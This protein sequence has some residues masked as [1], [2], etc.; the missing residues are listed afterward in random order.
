MLRS[1]LLAA[2]LMLV[3]VSSLAATTAF[4]FSASVTDVQGQGTINVELLSAFTGLTTPGTVITGAFSYDPTDA[5]VP[6]GSDNTRTQLGAG[7]SVVAPSFNTFMAGMT[8]VGKTS[9]IS[10]YSAT[11]DYA[12]QKLTFSATFERFSAEVG[13]DRRFTAQMNLNFQH[14]GTG[15]LFKTDTFPADVS[16]LPWDSIVLSMVIAED[17]VEAAPSGATTLVGAGLLRSN[18]TSIQSVAVVPVPA[19]LPLL[20]VGLGVLGWRARMPR[21]A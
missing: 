1:T 3:P 10:D 20:V 16:A 15:L 4:E 19:S 17:R 14:E 13:F 6:S 9:L 21:A 8:Q 5:G 18:V 7:L 2:G 12:F 11:V